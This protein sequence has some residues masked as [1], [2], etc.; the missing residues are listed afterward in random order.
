MPSER[1]ERALG[2]SSWLGVVVLAGAFAEVLYEHTDCKLV[3]FD[4]R[5]IADRVYC[6]P[7]F[8]ICVPDSSFE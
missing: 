2:D 8:V 7:G 5:L 4:Q 1:Y 6:A 3:A